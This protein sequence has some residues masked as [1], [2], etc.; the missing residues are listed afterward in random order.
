MG[1]IHIYIS[2]HFLE[3]VMNFS[4]FLSK[5]CDQ[6]SILLTSSAG[7]TVKQTSKQT[8]NQEGM[9]DFWL[10]NPLYT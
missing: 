4:L 10:E 5:S 7:S 8:N 9:H 6:S 3:K 1:E 2:N